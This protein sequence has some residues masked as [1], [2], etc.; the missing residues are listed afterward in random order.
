MNMKSIPSY[1]EHMPIREFVACCR[2]KLFINYDGFGKYATADAM[3]DKK[4][5]PSEITDGIIDES[6]THVVWFNR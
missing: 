4:V 1:G 2:R 3:S 6:F 5:L